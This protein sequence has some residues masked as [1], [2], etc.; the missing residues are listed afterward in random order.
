MAEGR[1]VGATF[2]TGEVSGPGTGAVEVRLLVDSGAM[3]SVLPHS[4]WRQLGL[5]PKRTERFTLADGSVVRRSV[6]ECHISLPQGSTHTPVIL[7]EPGDA[8][9]L[10]VVTLEELGLM[11]NPFDR[12]LQPMALRL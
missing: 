10:G 4:V 7:G 1:S 5:S 8:A 11:L 2:I 6:S 12:T 9:L 3:Y